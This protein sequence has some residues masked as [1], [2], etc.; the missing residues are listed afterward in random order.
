MGHVGGQAVGNQLA[1]VQHDAAVAQGLGGVFVQSERD[2]GDPATSEGMV[3]PPRASAGMASAG[4]RTTMGP[5]LR[6]TEGAAGA[7]EDMGKFRRMN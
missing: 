3:G 7:G 6:D 5:T 2:D 1:M 4:R